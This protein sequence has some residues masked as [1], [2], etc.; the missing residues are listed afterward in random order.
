MSVVNVKFTW[1][2]TRAG[3]DES[4]DTGAMGWTVLVTESDPKLGAEVAKT[5]P[6]IPRV[7][8]GHPADAAKRCTSVNARALGPRFFEVVAEFKAKRGGGTPGEE[9]DDPRARRPE[10]RWATVSS[11]EPVDEDSA[12]DPIMNTAQQPLDP[13]LVL[14]FNDLA[15]SVIRNV[16]TNAAYLWLFEGR[17]AV[18]AEPFLGFQP[19]EARTG[20][21]AAEEV[22]EGATAYLRETLEFRFRL[23]GWKRRVLNQGRVD[24]D[25]KV[26]CDEFGAGVVEPVWL[27]EA[28]AAIPKND[29]GQYTSGP[30]WLDLW[31]IPKATFSAIGLSA[32]GS[33]R[34]A[35]A[36]KPWQETV[37]WQTG[38]VVLASAQ[39]TD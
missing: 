28:G 30:C 25:G 24:A 32:D 4:G 10:F 1:S 18:N 20:A 38:G 14:D 31:L 29:K 19:F 35:L 27:D 13:P 8:D 15:L 5:A 36:A 2:E 21:Y 7:Y 23:G 37:K 11:S 33:G 12:G 9:P 34:P 22:V 26:I 3:S 39:K 6:G 16:K 17:G